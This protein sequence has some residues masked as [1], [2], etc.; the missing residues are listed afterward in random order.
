MIYDY[1]KSFIVEILRQL[2]QG[3]DK[4]ASL[5]LRGPISCFGVDEISREK[6]DRSFSLFFVQLMDRDLKSFFLIIV[7]VKDE[8]LAKVG[9]D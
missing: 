7:D 2:G 6:Q 9:V 8:R 5:K 4:R 1:D 3:L